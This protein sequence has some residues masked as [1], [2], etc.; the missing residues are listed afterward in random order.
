LSS[1]MYF[2]YFETDLGLVILL[3]EIKLVAPIP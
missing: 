2:E 3:P 1:F